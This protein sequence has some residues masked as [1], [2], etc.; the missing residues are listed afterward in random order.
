[1]EIP[2]IRMNFIEHYLTFYTL[3]CIAS[4]DEFEFAYNFERTSSSKIFFYYIC[5]MHI[6]CNAWSTSWHLHQRAGALSHC[7]P[8]GQW[9]R[10]ALPASTLRGV[11]SLRSSHP[12]SAAVPWQVPETSIALGRVLA[13]IERN[14]CVVCYRWTTANIPRDIKNVTVSGEPHPFWLMWTGRVD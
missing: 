10:T 13:F 12:T 3:T 8:L 9:W 11:S 14:A 7:G 2:V 6:Q 4:R 5:D 1:M